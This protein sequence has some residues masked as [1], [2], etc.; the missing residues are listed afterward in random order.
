MADT[1]MRRS[2]YVEASE[3]YSKKIEKIKS[4]KQKDIVRYK[5]ASCY[6]LMGLDNRSELLYKRLILRRFPNASIY[7]YYGSC[8]L[9]KGKIEDAIN[10]FEEYK[11]RK[12]QDYRWKKELNRCKLIKSWKSMASKVKLEK[13]LSLS[14]PG[15][16]FLPYYDSFKNLIYIPKSEELAPDVLRYT[17]EKL[18]SNIFVYKSIKGKWGVREKVRSIS[19]KYD[20]VSFLSRDN[21]TYITR[22]GSK[23]NDVKC[24]VIV[25]KRDSLNQFIYK[26]NFEFSGEKFY[27]KSPTFSLDGKILY[28][29]STMEG[30][31]GGVDIWKVDLGSRSKL[32]TPKNLGKSI[33]TKGNEINPYIS[34][35]GDL[36][37]ST[38]RNFGMGGYDI[39]KAFKKQGK[40]RV[41]ILKYPINSV[42]NDVA[43]SFVRGSTKGFVVSDRGTGLSNYDVFTFETAVNT[44][45]GTIYDSDSKKQINDVS[46]I[47]NDKSGV[48]QSQNTTHDGRFCFE[49]ISSGKLTIHK[50]GYVGYTLKIKRID[51]FKDIHIKKDL[52]LCKISEPCI[53]Y[54][55]QFDGENLNKAKSAKALEFLLNHLSGCREFE[56]KKIVIK[57]YTNLHKTN[58]R[59]FNL[60]IGQA[61]SLNKFLETNI[62]INTKYKING[63]GNV[64]LVVSKGLSDKYHGILMKG[65]ELTLKKLRSIPVIKRKKLRLLGSRVEIFLM[66]KNN[67]NYSLSSDKKDTLNIKKETQVIK[68]LEKK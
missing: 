7:L 65:D 5:L 64:P 29:E 37:Y 58:S 45:D 2:N 41:K 3:I 36:Y 68:D 12:P 13:S 38:N 17:K 18:K 23:K 42:S 15:D 59:N 52:N 24:R 16:D 40:W 35:Q 6:R 27:I 66:D 50:E 53:I 32:G 55:L 21:L 30:G 9:K 46:L 28:F 44:I 11:S 1:L 8:L 4:L 43:I 48:V 61:R 31:L 56:N 63:L 34:S 51:F 25:A 62:P 67:S 60:S 39:L 14:G 22:C 33:N 57:L 10:M 54:G 20:E 26:P 19:T 49:K 47:Y